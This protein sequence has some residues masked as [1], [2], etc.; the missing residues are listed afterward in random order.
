M[1]VCVHE[2][3]CGY[4][5]RS[6]APLMHTHDVIRVVIL[7]RTRV[8]TNHHLIGAVALPRLCLMRKCLPPLPLLSG[9]WFITD[10]CMR[11]PHQRAARGVRRGHSGVAGV[12]RQHSGCEI[13]Q[14][15][16]QAHV[17]HHLGQ[18]D[19]PRL[20][21]VSPLLAQLRTCVIMQTRTHAHAHMQWSQCQKEC[22]D[23]I[24][25][26]TYMHTIC[27]TPIKWCVPVRHV[28]IPTV[29]LDN[30]SP[31]KTKREWRIAYLHNLDPK[32]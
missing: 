19:P 11:A 7:Y 28:F 1:Y 13:L 3:G 12:A 30:E 24:I 23:T 17:R 9:G 22:G 5:I 10:V 29:L 14:R 26:H 6:C 8:P 18:A 2:C 32:V 31:D 16:P 15:L 27:C 25:L 21:K 20:Y 4:C